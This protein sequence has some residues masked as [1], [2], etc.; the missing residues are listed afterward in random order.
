MKNWDREFIDYLF[1]C[2]DHVSFL[3]GFFKFQETPNWQNPRPLSLQEFSLR[4]GY[5]T[6]SYIHEILNHKKNSINR[7]KEKIAELIIEHAEEFED[8]E[9]DTIA[10]ICIGLTRST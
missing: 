2:T 3:Q 6:K 7:L 5:K 8:P 4:A 9:G 10:E 1:K